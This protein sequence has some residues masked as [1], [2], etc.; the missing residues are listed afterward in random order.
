MGLKLVILGFVLSL[1]NFRTA[2][3]L[4]PLR[5]TWP[6]MLQIAAVFG[7]FDAVAPLIGILIGHDIDSKRG[8]GIAGQ[9]GV[10]ALGSYG[11]YLIARALQ[12]GTQEELTGEHRWSVFGLPVPLS[13]DN[14]IAGA[15]LGMLGL[16]PF[17]PA[18]LFGVITMAMTFSGLQL[19]RAASRLIP[20]RVRWDALVG[21]ALIIE[22]LVLGISVFPARG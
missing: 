15:G 1:D 18:A 5:F 20:I 22:A 2:V 9:V 14:L 19:G 8:D 4:G 16:S 13:L 21:A 3:I 12:T 7:F 6:H 10:I 17:M 11:L